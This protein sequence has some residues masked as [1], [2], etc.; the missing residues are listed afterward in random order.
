M[1]QV[2]NNAE[3]TPVAEIMVQTV[4]IQPEAAANL[5][6]AAPL[7]V[8]LPAG[9]KIAIDGRDVGGI[10]FIVCN[11]KSCVARATLKETD[12]QAFKAGNVAQ[13]TIVPAENPRAPVAVNSSLAGFTAGFDQ[14]PKSN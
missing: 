1:F 8:F 2:L 14:L 6:V 11:T 5:I 12:V 3:G 13:I 9:V 4:N 7:G 10:P